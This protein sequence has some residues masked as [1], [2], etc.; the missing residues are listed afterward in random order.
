MI[1]VLKGVINFARNTKRA[2]TA[3][4]S[5]LDEAHQRLFA[6]I[7]NVPAKQTDIGVVMGGTGTSGFT[8]RLAAEEFH[9]GR[10]EKI[11]VAGGAKVVK[12]PGLKKV[13]QLFDSETLSLLDPEDLESEK[14]EADYIYDVLV[15]AGVPEEAIQKAGADK[16]NTDEIVDSVLRHEFSKSARSM[17]VVAYGPGAQRIRSTFRMQAQDLHAGARGQDIDDKAAF[18]GAIVP[19]VAGLGKMQPHN[20]KDS[21]IARFY[22]MAEAHNMAPKRAGRGGFIDQYCLDPE[23]HRDNE[24]LLI[25]ELP[26]MEPRG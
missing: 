22:V 6:P 3:S 8:A 1:G 15:K 24:D 25:A 18:E 7:E 16:N 12:N 5:A 13:L 21:L 2:I 20:W 14:S 10:Y 26:D 9:K 11:I 19:I 23:S 17:T 4:D